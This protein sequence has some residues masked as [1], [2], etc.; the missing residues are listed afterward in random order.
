MPDELLAGQDTPALNSEVQTPEAEP[1][2]TVTDAEATEAE[3]TEEKETPVKTFTQ[4]ELDSIVQKRLAKERSKAE[5][6]V[7]Q[8]YREALESVTRAKP[9][10][11][12][13]PAEPTRDQFASDEEWVDARVQHALKKK[14]S[15][16][17]AKQQTRKSEELYSEAEKIPGFDRDDFDSLPLTPQIAQFLLE[18]DASPKLMA[19]MVKNESEVERISK[20]SP[21][22]QFAELGKIEGKLSSKPAIKPSTTPAPI[23]PIGR[24]KSTVKTAE[25]MSMDE[26]M[27][28]RRKE[29]ASWARR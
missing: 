18:S 19:Y 12:D 26:Y 6:Q 4:E 7:A 27:E 9:A 23:E 10:Q 11:A 8:A 2:Q 15:Q 25:N 20:L 13:T 5:R 22:R 29:G 21:A 16:E 1:V 17:S 24:G 28:M 14:E 3:H